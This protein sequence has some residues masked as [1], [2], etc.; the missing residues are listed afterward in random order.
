LQ[1]SYLFFQTPSIANTSA[2]LPIYN[3]STSS[4][5]SGSEPGATVSQENVQELK[6]KRIIMFKQ[7]VI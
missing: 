2:V 1:L 6:V 7:F 3:H 4:S 5:F